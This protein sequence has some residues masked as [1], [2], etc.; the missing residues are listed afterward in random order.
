MKVIVLGAGVVGLSSAIRLSDAGFDVTV[1]ADKVSPQTTSDVAAAIWYPYKAEPIEKMKVWGERT[2]ARLV[3]LADVPDSGVVLREGVKYFHRPMGLPWWKDIVP[4]FRRLNQMELPANVVAGYRFKV[5]VADMSVY[6]GFL[7][8]E[9]RCRSIEIEKGFEVSL[10]RA[11]KLCGLVI[12]CTGLG[13]R[14]LIKDDKVFSI[15][16]QVVRVEG[17][18]GNTAP[19]FPHSTIGFLPIA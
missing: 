5:P 14:E 7:Q 9:L 19:S 18:S 12:N 3:E 17:A 10:N 2:C 11:L 13:A 8:G 15:W 6:M 4:G 1:W 16:G